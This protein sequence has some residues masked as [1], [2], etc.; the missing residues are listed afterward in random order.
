M[1]VLKFWSSARNPGSE[2][3]LGAWRWAI[4]AP[5]VITLAL[6]ALAATQGRAANADQL[7]AGAMLMWSAD[8]DRGGGEIP[9]ASVPELTSKVD[10]SAAVA[11]SNAET[12]PE[13][14]WIYSPF[15]DCWLLIWS[16]RITVGE[17]LESATTCKGYNPGLSPGI[18]QLTPAAFDYR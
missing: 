18:G 4:M 9:V 6:V 14:E 8:A 13:N 2:G 7:Q 1:V 11:E 17:G 3:T 12:W 10:V 15:D 5:L 16:G